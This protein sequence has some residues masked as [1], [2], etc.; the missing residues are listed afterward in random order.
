MK[1]GQKSI[2][3]FKKAIIISIAWLPTLS[4]AS[5]PLD[6]ILK[7]LNQEIANQEIYRQKKEYRITSLR[8]DLYQAKN[9][10]VRFSTASMLF[11]EYRC[12]QSD[13]AYY[14]AKKMGRIAENMNYKV[15]IVSSKIAQTDY[16]TSIGLFKEACDVNSTINRDDVQKDQI[17][18]YYSVNARL[19]YNL[20]AYVGDN[21]PE[22]SQQYYDIRKDYY[23]KLTHIAPINSYEYNHA[24]LALHEINGKSPLQNIKMRLKFLDTYDITDH[25][26]AIQ[27]SMVGHSYLGLKHYDEAKYY[28]ALSA[29]YDIRSNTY[30]TTSA[31]M[32]AELMYKDGDY[33]HAYTYI[34]LAFNDAIFY[35]SH[36][37]RDEIISTLKM[38]ENSRYGSLVNRMWHLGSIA[39]II[40]LLLMMV[41]ILLYKF[42]KANR[43]LKALNERLDN[44][45]CELEQKQIELAA[46]NDKLSKILDQLKETT[47]IKDEYIMQSLYVNTFFVNQVEEKAHKVVKMVKNEQY[48]KLMLL[49]YQMGIK[50]ERQRIFKQFDNA[51]LS[52][53][54]NFVDELNK[55]FDK[56]NQIVLNADGGLPV[57]VRIFALMRL[58]ISDPSVVAKYLNLSTKT[59]Y[60][61]KTKMKSRSI[62]DNNDFENRIMQ[63]PKP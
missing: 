60:V 1:L 30:E 61:Y 24:V 40:T 53:F 56:D 31:K 19:Y 7:V 49:P 5:A 25:E 51:F 59:V 15:G 6:S 57:E 11:D 41:A 38:I 12:Y 37:R 18:A 14:Y 43:H 28:L 52:L 34:H 21:V 48:D 46:I 36:L 13:S 27:Y 33:T 44:K 22:L 32:L 62:V 23:K 20:G 10:T 35:N 42:K 55:L 29:I 8:Q 16:F 26:K 45:T 2:Q 54:P 39:F 4:F 3:S 50:E 47:A 9:D 58:N 63:I 17:L